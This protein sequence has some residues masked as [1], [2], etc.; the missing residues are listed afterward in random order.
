MERH[1]QKELESLKTSL[2]KMGSVVEEN[3]DRSIQSVI[4]KSS[5]LADQVIETDQTGRCS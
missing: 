5:T 1:F 3:F 2:V 4:E